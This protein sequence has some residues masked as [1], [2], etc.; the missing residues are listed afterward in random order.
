MKPTLCT[1][2]IINQMIRPH[3]RIATNTLLARFLCGLSVPVFTKIKAR[4]LTGFATLE[5][6]RYEDV[7]GAVR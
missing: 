1:A 6:Y 5:P 4:K 2:S 7:L 3:S